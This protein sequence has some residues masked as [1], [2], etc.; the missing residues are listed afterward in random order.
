MS[1]GAFQCWK[2]LPE[3]KDAAGHNTRDRAGWTPKD[4]SKAALGS[5]GEGTGSCSHQ[6]A[7]AMF[8]RLIA[9]VAK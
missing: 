3:A 6:V 9:Q 7:C 8:L 1:A 5:A 2:N 4:M